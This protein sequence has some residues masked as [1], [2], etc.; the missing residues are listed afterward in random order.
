MADGTTQEVTLNDFIHSNAFDVVEPYIRRTAASVALAKHLDVYKMSDVDKLIAEATQN[1]L[2]SEF[3]SNAEIAKTR[4]HLQFTFDRIL[5][6]P[7]EEFTK[8]NKGL[9]MWRNFNV[10]R[11]MGGAVWNQAIEFA[12]IVGTM[13]WKASLQ[14]M[15]ELRALRRD[16]A[17]GKAPNEILDHLENTIGGV[18]S[19]YIARLDFKGSDDWVRNLGDTKFNQRLDALDNGLKKM[20]RG[21]LD[22]TG[23]TPLMVQQKRVH[24]VALV[25][26]FVNQANGKIQSKFLTKERLAWM[27]LSEGDTAKFSKTYK[28]D[29]DKWV[30]EDPESHSKFMTAIHRESRR[31]VQEND[32]ASMVPIMGTT[33]GKTVFQFMNFSIHGWNKSLNFAL[34]HKD[35]STLS[36]VLH[37]SFMA[38]LAYMG[39]TAVQSAGMDEEKK[40]E[41]LSKRFNTGQI[42]ANSFG[43]LAQV[44][45][46]PNIYDTL[47]PYPM[48]Q[49][50]RTTS[51][52]SSLASNPT[53][54][55]VNTLISMKKAVRN[56]TS[57][58]YQTT[59]KDIKA[60][61]KLLPLQNIYPMTSILNSLA[62][63]YPS[64]EQQD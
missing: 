61:T 18:G 38:S 41:F 21:V 20:A 63:D 9:S 42:V 8:L 4:E 53:Y 60:W 43:R 55:A 34:N 31:V 19:E 62:N 6:I 48:F 59:S 26:H 28:L 54:Q 40:R 11:L 15:P 7:E 27:G 58:E 39:R 14:A 44:S 23:M 33:L 36:T 45:L 32:L 13:G 64:T 50:M 29:L 25:N 3:T 2:G 56:A 12:Q 47:S 5:G 10:M 22:Y 35:Y 16:L 46:L 52:L 51:D 17:T 30:K 37:G 49:G 1:K 57:D 24:A